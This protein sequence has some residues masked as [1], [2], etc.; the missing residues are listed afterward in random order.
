MSLKP[1]V[2]FLPGSFTPADLYFPIRDAVT[3][4]GIDA[5]VLPLPTVRLGPHDKRPAPSM[6]DDA[7]AI[8]SKV[9]RLADEGKDVIVISSSYSGVPMTQSCKGLSKTERQNDG[10]KGGLVMLAYMPSTVPA[11]GQAATDILFDVS[12]GNQ[13]PMDLVVRTSLL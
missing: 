3:A 11:I 10:K 13:M 2:I 9:E 5:H 7:A 4:R 12:L 8:S 1:S 6:Y